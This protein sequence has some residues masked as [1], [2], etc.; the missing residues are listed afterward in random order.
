MEAK[1]GI[2][3]SS[4]LMFQMGETHGQVIESQWR[5]A[6]AASGVDQ[7]LIAEMRK[8]LL[9]DLWTLRHQQQGQLE[10]LAM[11][12]EEEK[13]AMILT[14]KK[15][16]LED[17]TF[18]EKSWLFT[19]LIVIITA[20]IYFSATDTDYSSTEKILLNWVIS[21]LSAISGIFCVVLAAKGKYSNWIWGIANSILYGYLAWKSGYYGDMLINIVYFLPT[22]FIGLAAWKKMMKKGSKTDVK[23]RELTLLQTIVLIAGAVIGTILFGLLL[24][25]VDNWFT[26][27]MRRNQSIYAY[28]AQLFGLRMKLAGPIV[29]AS[30]EVLQVLAQIFMIL[31]FAEQWLLWIM[32]NV[33]TIIMWA[34]VIIADPTSVSWAVPTLIMWIAYLINSVYGYCNW[35]KGAK[36]ETGL[37]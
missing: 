14:T 19:F 2:F 33:I 25:G 9:D 6:I 24:N 20:T 17:W 18:F 11:R 30:T 12:E 26:T 4:D 16:Y 10:R 1:R 5:D 28:F 31:A 32:T 23:M 35:R 36:A 15:K 37:L 22:Q 34:I 3:F 8:E 13:K 27:V 21:P 29:D 7:L